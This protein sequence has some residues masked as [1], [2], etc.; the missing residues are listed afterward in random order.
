MV[1]LS[2]INPMYNCLHIESCTIT[3][4]IYFCYSL[5]RCYEY[6]RHSAIKTSPYEVVFSQPACAGVFPGCSEM[7]IDEDDLLKVLQ[8]ASS[9]PDPM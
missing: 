7:E 3:K 2:S 1:K 5:Q 8:D 9:I 6:Q 4:R